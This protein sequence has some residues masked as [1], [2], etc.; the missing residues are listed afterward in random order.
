MKRCLTLALLTCLVLT[1]GHARLG[2]TLAKIKE[3]FG[4]APDSQPQ[5]NSAVWYFEVEDGQVVY[6]VTFDARGLSIAEGLKPLKR[7]M[8]TRDIAQDF[9]NLQ[10]ALYKDSK[11]ARIVNPGEKYGFAGKA[12][13]CGE[14]EYVIVDEPNHFLLVWTRGGLPSVIAVRPEMIQ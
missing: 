5:K 2:E 14:Q 13:V 11:T 3:H 1:T 7:A 8:F 4:R 10:T 12:F 9:I 6:T